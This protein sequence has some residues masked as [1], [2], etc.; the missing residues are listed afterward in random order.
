MR[1]DLGAMVLVPQGSFVMRELHP[2]GCRQE[3]AV[4]LSQD[5]YLGEHEVTNGEYLP[6]LQWA[7][8]QGHI[9]VTASAVLDNLGCPT[10]C[11][12]PRHYILQDHLTK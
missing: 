4:A 6:A 12:I 11:A 5:F 10:H 8:D 3:H 9:A 2:S 1:V 7:Y